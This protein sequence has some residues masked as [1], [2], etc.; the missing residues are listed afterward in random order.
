MSIFSKYV[1]AADGAVTTEEGSLIDLV[2]PLVPLAT[3]EGSV[4][5]FVALLVLAKVL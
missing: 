4:A 3:T 2:N 5:R 1:Q